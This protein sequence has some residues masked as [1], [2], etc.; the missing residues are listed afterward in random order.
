MPA[1]ITST[2]LTHELTSQTVTIANGSS[3]SGAADLK[4]SRLHHIILP[5]GFV[6]ADLTFAVSDDDSTYVPLYNA[7]GEYKIP[8]SVVAASRC[9]LVDFPT[10]F[11]FRFV[12]IRSG[13]SGAAA[14]V[15]GDQVITF[16]STPRS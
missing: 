12:K 5:V 15:T 14:N 7:S 10:F 2:D 11:G 16:S 4:A 3:L 9:I 1:G 8:A 13:T 6:S